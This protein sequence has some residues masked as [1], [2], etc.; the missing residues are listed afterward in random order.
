VRLAINELA[1]AGARLAFSLHLHSGFV[2][3]DPSYRRKLVIENR[4]ADAA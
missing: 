4:N 3:M 1:P 2:G